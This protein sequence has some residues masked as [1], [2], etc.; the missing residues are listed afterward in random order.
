LEL[1][2]D[3]INC[4]IAVRGNDMGLFSSIGDALQGI[5]SAVGIGGKRKAGVSPAYEVNAES[6]LAS[7]EYQTQMDQLSSEIANPRTGAS[8]AELLMKQEGENAARQAASIMASQRGTNPALAARTAASL[9]TDARMQASGQAGVMRANEDI[10][11]QKFREGQRATLL[12]AA[13]ANRQAQIQREGMQSGAYQANANQQFQAEEGAR[14]RLGSF[15]SGVG[16]AAMM[17]GMMKG[18]ASLKD[19]AAGT[20]AVSDRNSKENIEGGS[21]EVRSF[22]DALEPY[23]YNYKDADQPQG[24]QVGVMAQDIEKTPMKYMVNENQGE[25]Q[26][27]TVG[28]FGAVLAALADLHG[29]TKMLEGGK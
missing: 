6:F 27:D 26:I 15:I 21:D 5:G 2:K 4:Q 7:P 20:A 13:D 12:G 3:Y 29:R 10:A 19:A 9:G 1:R 24:K 18:G 25:K 11:Q 16:N 22:L 28:G 17:G 14:G 23:A 8:P